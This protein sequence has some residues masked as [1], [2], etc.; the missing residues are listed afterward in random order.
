MKRLIFLSA[1]LLGICIT[2]V[3]A[4]DFGPADFPGDIES[5]G[6][7]S[8]HDGWCR[9][10]KKE[11]RIRFQGRSMTVEGYKGIERDQLIS[12]RTDFEGAES[13]FYV[14]YLNSRGKKTTALFLFSHR[15]ASSEFGRALARWYKQ[16]ARPFPNY[17]YPNSQGPQDTHGR[18]NGLNLY[19]Q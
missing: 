14:T 16:D 1:A 6:P 18:D 12:F 5:K 8:Y 3:I 15:I 17:R 4:D 13:Y 10:I 7:L 2:P 19:D 11:C 9:Q